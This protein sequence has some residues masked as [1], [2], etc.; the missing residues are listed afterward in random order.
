MNDKYIYQNTALRN[1]EEMLFLK[2]GI[3]LQDRSAD[4]GG[5]KVPLQEKENTYIGYGIDIIHA[6]GPTDLTGPLFK[7]SVYDGTY[8]KKVIDSAPKNESRIESVESDSFIEMF[9]NLNINAEIRVGKGVPFF[10]G[11]FS[12]HYGDSRKLA[13]TAKFYNSIVYFCKNKHTLAPAFRSTEN[14]KKLI[15]E[16]VLKDINNKKI[17]P[18]DIFS[19]YGTHIIK[20]A[21]TGGSTQVTAIY[22]STNE[23]Q[24]HELKAAVDF[25]C[26]YVSTKDDITFSEDKKAI[27]NNTEIRGFCQGGNAALMAGLVNFKQLPDFLRKWSESL[28]NSED[29]V[30]AETLKYIPIWEL[31][32]EPSRKKEIED[33]FFKMAEE[34]GRQVSGYFTKVAPFELVSMSA[35]CGQENSIGY[36]S[37]YPTDFLQRHGVREQII[38]KMT[39]ASVIGGSFIEPCHKINKIENDDGTFSFR[40]SH[41]NN[42]YLRVHFNSVEE[43]SAGADIQELFIN[44]QTISE[45]EKFI[46]EKSGDG[47]KIKSVHNNKYLRTRHIHDF[48][49]AST[50]LV[51]DV[52]ENGPEKPTVFFLKKL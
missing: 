25:A 34:M 51:A 13:K 12:A 19:D 48:V 36:V 40:F 37:G 42:L 20:E 15:E 5:S 44:G 11:G 24:N 32:D 3:S 2:K 46:L 7:D 26:A 14:I 30:L 6:I 16:D 38:Q 22:N 33:I 1:K 17:P 43:Q 39:G 41:Y 47:Y 8:G 52:S 21:T 49:S 50:T 28:N 18:A 4:Q 9:T 10:S 23:L 27:L 35:E 31:V 45:R 29:L